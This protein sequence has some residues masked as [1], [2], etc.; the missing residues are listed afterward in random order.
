MINAQADFKLQR[1]FAPTICGSI[2][3]QPFVKKSSAT[4]KECCL[5]SSDD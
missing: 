3:D 2:R 4:A 5:L 1:N